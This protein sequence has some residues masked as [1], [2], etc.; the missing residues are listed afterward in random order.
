MRSNAIHEEE[1]LRLVT[2]CRQSGLSDAQWCLENG[3]SPSSFYNWT[4]RL[5]HKG[6]SLPAPGSVPAL[7][8]QDIVRVDVVPNDQEVIG[9]SLEGVSL[10]SESMEA[11]CSHPVMEL[12]LGNDISLK[13]TNE[14]DVTILAS[15][16]LSLKGQS[17]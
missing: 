3:I 11:K 10:R 12:A 16:M 6:I 2:K 14:V 15:L 9:P 13:I 7:S 5:R 1:Q 8:K 17:C 4:S